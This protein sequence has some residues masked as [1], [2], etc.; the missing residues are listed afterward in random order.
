MRFRI[1]AA[2]VLLVA[3]LFSAAEAG[4]GLRV[5]RF[6]E[7]LSWRGPQKV[8]ADAKGRVFLLRAETLEVHPILKTG[9]LGEA[10]KLEAARSLD[11]PVL[12][13]AMGSGPG[14]W[15][16]RLPLEVRGFANGKEKTLPP[17][18]WQPWSVGYLRGTPLVSV[19]P[20]PAPVNGVM[21]LQKDE[22][23]PASAPAVLTLG[24]DRWS[25]LIDET[26]PARR[27]SNTLTEHGARLLLGARDG[28]IWTAHS[29]SYHLNRFSPA[30]R[31]LATMEPEKQRE[32]QKAD[33]KPPSDL[34]AADR[35]R[36]QPFRGVLAVSDLTEGLDGRIYLL[37][38]GDKGAALDRYDS[39]QSTLERLSLSLTL[40]GNATLA[41]G[42]DALYLAAHTGD[43][44]RW[45]I[46][47]EDLEQA[48]WHDVPLKDAPPTA[49][50]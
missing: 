13:A 49:K 18:P 27:D 28:K 29:Y 45:K 32:A 25:V 21:I 36:F 42:R 43:A 19:L 39:T 44:G 16:L 9:A 23:G 12:D 15:L 30:G 40:P 31:L 48:D 17:L 26:W 2:V 11:A 24:G 8:Q 37:V 41:A 20:K 14:D 46:T 35:K 1:A 5:Q 3:A 47:W 7:N 38:Q 10:V 50:K 22:E 6:G 4:G 34:P 33:P